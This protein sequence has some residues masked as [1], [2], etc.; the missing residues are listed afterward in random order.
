[1]KLEFSRQIFR[2]KKLKYRISNFIKILPGRVDLFQ[3]DGRTDV[4][5]IIVA[6]RNFANAPENDKQKIEYNGPLH[7]RVYGK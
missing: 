7:G 3:A 6:F 1:M 4:T 2:G 5:K